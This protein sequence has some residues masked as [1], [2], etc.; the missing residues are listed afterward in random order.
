MINSRVSQF[1]PTKATLSSYIQNPICSKCASDNVASRAG[2]CEGDSNV[3]ACASGF[4][5]RLC[6][7]SVNRMSSD[8][9]EESRKLKQFDTIMFEEFYDSGEKETQFEIRSST[10]PNL[11]MLSNENDE[12]NYNLFF[13]EDRGRSVN[14]LPIDRWDNGVKYHK[15]VIEKKWLGVLLMNLSPETHDVNLKMSSKL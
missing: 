4:T 6:D 11:I 5:G 3:C 13:M 14:I 12:Q 8:T 1:T 15:I 9:L 10:S 2:G 7:R